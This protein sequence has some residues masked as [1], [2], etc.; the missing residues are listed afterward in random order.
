[1][2]HLNGHPSLAAPRIRAQCVVDLLSRVQRPWTFRVTVWSP[3][4]PWR[5]VYEIAGLSDGDVA[6]QGLRRFEQDVWLKVRH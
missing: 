3:D 6:E 2:Q 5:A 4:V 1:M